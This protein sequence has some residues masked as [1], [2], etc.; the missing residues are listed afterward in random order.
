M[1]PAS[2]VPIIAHLESTLEVYKVHIRRLTSCLGF[3]I[4]IIMRNSDVSVY[5]INSA[6][7]SCCTENKFVVHIVCLVFTLEC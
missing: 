7:A 5:G 2:S 1:E 6:D 3:I 4:I